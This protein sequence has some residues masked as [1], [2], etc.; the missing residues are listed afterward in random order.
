MKLGERYPD[1]R[2]VTRTGS[3]A[4]FAI[5]TCARNAFAIILLWKI[6][7]LPLMVPGA[8]AGVIGRRGTLN[9][10]KELMQ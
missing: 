5:D 4:H 3:S 7:P 1:R 6:E 2:L 8:I 9:W 10:V